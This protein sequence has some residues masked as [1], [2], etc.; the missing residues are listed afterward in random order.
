MKCDVTLEVIKYVDDI[1]INK[2]LLNM[3]KYIKNILPKNDLLNNRVERILNFLKVQIKDK[4]R[5]TVL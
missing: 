1:S 5:K 4:E 2:E 3:L